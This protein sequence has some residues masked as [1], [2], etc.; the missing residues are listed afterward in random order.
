MAQAEQ[1]GATVTMTETTVT[2]VQINFVLV[3]TAE[4]FTE[5]SG[6]ITGQNLQSISFASLPLQATIPNVGKVASSVK[7]GLRSLP[8]G[9]MITTILSEPINTEVMDTFRIALAEE[10]RELIAVAYT[11]TVIKTN[12]DT[13][14]PATITMTCPPDWI[15]THGGVNSVSIVRIGDDGTTQV[16][17]TTHIGYDNSG[18]M[19]FEAISPDGLSI[20]GLITS[21]ITAIK[22]AEDPNANIVPLSQPAMTTNF[23]MFIW[24]LSRVQEN[25]LIMLMIIPLIVLF[26]CVDLLR[27]RGKNE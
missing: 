8:E 19:V 6:I 27:R 15:T 2:V 26:V 22:L 24:V 21:K 14:L 3:M 5:K 1:T 17:E 7:A 16:L 13:T 10:G 20:F 25:P 12:I 9:A 18:N 23:G 11:M 4:K